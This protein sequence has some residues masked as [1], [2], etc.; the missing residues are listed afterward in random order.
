MPSSRVKGPHRLTRFQIDEVVWPAQLVTW[1][2]LVSQAAGIGFLLFA[3]LGSRAALQVR[4][5]RVWWSPIVA[6]LF[7]ILHGLAGAW[8]GARQV[9]G[10][11]LAIALFSFTLV[12]R[13]L[14]RHLL[15]FNT[16]YAVLA[17]ILIVRAG[18]AIGV[19]YLTSTA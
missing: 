2:P 7:L 6:L 11:W 16:A 4:A 1:L 14:H 18:R 10:I 19:R 13:V 8:I 5:P 3:M 15:S 9:R 17:L 12:S